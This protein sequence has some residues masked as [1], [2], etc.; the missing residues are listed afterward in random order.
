MSRRTT[1]ITRRSLARIWNTSRLGHVAP[2][3]RS[4]VTSLTGIPH[5][6]QVPGSEAG[7]VSRVAGST[8]LVHTDQQ[9]VAVTVEGH[10]ADVLD[11]TARVPLAPVLPTAA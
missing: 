4:G 1:G 9:G 3:V 7:A 5:C 2:K 8:H 10:G 6:A 11:V